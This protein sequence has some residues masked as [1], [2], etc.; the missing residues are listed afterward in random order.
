MTTSPSPADP[1]PPAAPGRPPS[2]GWQRFRAE[3]IRL[4]R[5]YANWLVTIS[6]KR[7]VVYSVAL[8]IGAVILQHLPPFSYTIGSVGEGSRHT[9]T[10]VPPLPPTPP[11]PSGLPSPPAPPTPPGGREPGV[12]IEKKDSKGNDVVISIDRDG[13]RIS[14]HVQIDRNGVRIGPGAIIRSTR[15][16]IRSG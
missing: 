4:F 8:L 2:T 12:K 11:S 1:S 5:L 6:W 9:V 13:V 3:T 16:K 10:V 15:R 14:P 7:F